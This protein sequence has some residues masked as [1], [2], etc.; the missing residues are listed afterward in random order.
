MPQKYLGKL[1][2]VPGAISWRYGDIFDRSKLLKPPLVFG[3]L[4]NSTVVDMLG[5]DKVG[6]CV[7][8]TQGHLLNNMQRGIGGAVST[9]SETSVIGDYSAVTGYVPG[10]PETDNGTMMADAAAYWRKTGIADASGLRHVI[11]AYVEIN[12]RNTDELMQA[13]FDFG[14]IALGVKF[15]QSAS[16]QW[17]HGQPWTCVPGTPKILGGHATSLVGRNSSGRAIIATWN[18][19]TAADMDWVAEFTDEAVAYISVSYL[20]SRGINP[21]GYDRAEMLRRLA[22]LGQAV[23]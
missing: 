7:F 19:I 18:G 11:D 16:D 9:F 1:P 17:D 23:V 12:I 21:R 2:H 8:A 5:N 20:D 15:P 10:K 13:A 3:H 22:G 14:G 4:W 6:D